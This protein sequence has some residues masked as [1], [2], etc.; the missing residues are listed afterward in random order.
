MLKIASDIL[1]AADLGDMTFLCQ[2]DLSAAFDTVDHDILVDR[3][4]R[5]FGL[6]GLFLEWIKSFLFKEHN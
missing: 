2:L 3:L 5:A 1:R 4:E 6:R